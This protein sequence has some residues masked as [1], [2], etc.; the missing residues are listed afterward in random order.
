[1]PVPPG[2]PYPRFQCFGSVFIWYGSESN[3]L[4][5]IPIRIQSGS[6]FWN[7]DPDPIRIQVLMTKNWKK[8]TATKN[9]ILFRSKSTIY[10]SQ[11]L[12]K[13]RPSFR[14]SLQPSKENSQNFKTWNFLIFF[15][16]YGSFFP[17][18]IRIGI[19]DPLTWLYPDPIRIRIRN[20]ARLFII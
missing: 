20:T 6:R 3:I 13:G 15:Y 9:Y 11:G 18:W 14:R 5:W 1:M 7:T 19:P 16:F 8:F 10:L 12:Q 2:T 4:G 17:S